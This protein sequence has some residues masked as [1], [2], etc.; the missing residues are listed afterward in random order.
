[1]LPLPHID[2]SL[3]EIAYSFDTLKADG[4]GIMTSYGDKWL[5]YPQFAPVWEEL[6]RRKATVYTHRRGLRRRGS[7]GDRAR[8]RAADHSTPQDRVGLWVARSG[9]S[10][11]RMRHPRA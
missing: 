8:E 5:G 10:N 1:M 2:A 7:D 3:E 11:S 6:N 9:F 4:V